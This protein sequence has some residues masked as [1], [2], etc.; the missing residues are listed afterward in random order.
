MSPEIRDEVI[1]NLPEDDIVLFCCE[2]CEEYWHLR[3]EYGKGFNYFVGV[4]T[5]H[6]LLSMMFYKNCYEGDK[7]TISQ[8]RLSEAQATMRSFTPSVYF[9]QDTPTITVLGN[10]YARKNSTFFFATEKLMYK[11]EDVLKNAMHVER[12][13]QVNLGAT[14]L[15]Q[16]TSGGVTIMVNGD[17]NVG[18][19]VVGRDKLISNK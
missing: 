2:T 13:S 16:Q 10:S 18:G 11:F 4:I 1:K 6:W 19:D 9:A 5:K 17:L 14:G 15:T 7:E 3:Q 8:M 12:H